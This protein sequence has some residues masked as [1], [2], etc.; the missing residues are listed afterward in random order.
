MRQL[1]LVIAAGVALAACDNRAPGANPQ[2]DAPAPGA[3]APAGQMPPAAVGTAID[4]QTYV[5]TAASAD[6]YEIRA[7]EMAVKRT[8]SDSVR[9]FAQR[10]MT[11]H[12]ATTE[13]L[14]RAAAATGIQVPAQMLPRHAQMLESLETATRG[15][16]P[17][18]F[19]RL[20][21]EQ[22]RTAHA[23]AVD[24]HRNMTG[25]ADLPAELATFARETLPKV[26][27]HLAMLTD[28]PAG[29]GPTGTPTGG[30][31]RTGAGAS[32]T[33][34]ATSAGGTSPPSPV[35]GSSGNS[36]AA[37]AGSSANPPGT[38]A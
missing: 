6:M 14:A 10:M 22:Q 20:Y 2:A 36:G 5:A 16:D 25:R 32:A 13:Q 17:A 29:P 27:G 11:E 34:P 19:D 38:S 15:N 23:E 18:A 3:A 31:S 24:L 30:E 12:R 21:L 4:P 33:P 37:G 8:R 35:T 1:P 7:S 28:M 26:E 9:D